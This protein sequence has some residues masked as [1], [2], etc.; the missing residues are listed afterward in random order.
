LIVSAGAHIDRQRFA[1]WIKEER[2]RP[3]DGREAALDETGNKDGL[4][5]EASG[6][7]GWP[8]KYATVRER[9][10]AIHLRRDQFA[11]PGQKL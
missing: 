9:A 6:D 7:A 8:D 10:F 2:I 1:F 4:E 5:T 3:R 11:H